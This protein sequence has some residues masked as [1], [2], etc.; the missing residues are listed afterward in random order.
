MPKNAIPEHDTKSIAFLNL[1][2]LKN[3]SNIP[4]KSPKDT[5]G[6]NVARPKTNMTNAASN[7]VDALLAVNAKK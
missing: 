5:I 4:C 7:N 3:E 6:I 1:A 2:L